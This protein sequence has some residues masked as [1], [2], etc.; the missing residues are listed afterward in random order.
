MAHLPTVVLTLA[1]TLAATACTAEARPGHAPPRRAARPLLRA[2]PAPIAVSAPRLG[3]SERPVCGNVVTKGP[4]QR[5]CTDAVGTSHYRQ[6][7]DAAA[8]WTFT[9]RDC[10]RGGVTVAIAP[11]HAATI[12][13]PG[14]GGQYAIT[15]VAPG[16]PSTE[17]LVAACLR[18]VP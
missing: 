8:S 17:P 18:G 14:A 4:A 10:Q 12:T 6:T 15:T 2:A 11:D 3:P 5:R 7:D 1:T 13:A 9:G 16:A